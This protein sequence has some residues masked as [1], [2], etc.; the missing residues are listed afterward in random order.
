MNYGIN[1][2]RRGLCI[3]LA[4]SEYTGLSRTKGC[5]DVKSMCFIHQ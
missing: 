5:F 4:M 1:S 3:G 2:F